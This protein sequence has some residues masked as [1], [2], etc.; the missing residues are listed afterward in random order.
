MLRRYAG[1]TG[2]AG[3]T[4]TFSIYDGADQQSLM[5]RVIADSGL[6]T[7]NFPPGSVLHRISAAKNRLLDAAGY[8]REAQDFHSK[9]V[10][11]LFAAYEKALRAANAADFDDLLLL[12]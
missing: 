7:G 1:A 8:A 6:N 9:T 11:R 4:G 5:K 12:T 2:A 10:A 3:V